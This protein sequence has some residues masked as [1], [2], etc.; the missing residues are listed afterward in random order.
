M[1]IPMTR[2]SQLKDQRP[3]ACPACV[4]CLKPRHGFALSSTVHASR[5]SPAALAAGFRV[6]YIGMLDLSTL[7]NGSSHCLSGFLQGIVL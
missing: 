1:Y 7:V 6:A 2:Y 5:A 3:D 4:D